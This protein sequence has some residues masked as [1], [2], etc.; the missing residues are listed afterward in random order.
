MDHHSATLPPPSKRVFLWAAPRSISNAF[1]RS[2]RELKNIKVFSGAH[3]RPH[4]Y[5]PERRRS[6]TFQP[7]QS[8]L[9]DSA[10]YEVVDA[11]LLGHHEGFEAV[12]V[13][14][15]ARYVEGRY[16]H[17]VRGG[18]SLFKHTF[19]IRH[20]KKSIPSL[21][22]VQKKCGFSS[23][24]IKRNGIRE[25]YDFFTIVKQNMDPHPI[26]IDADDLLENPRGIMEHYCKETGLPFEEQMLTWEPGEVKDWM[27]YTYSHVFKRQL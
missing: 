6:N 7:T 23:S 12:F 15:D 27:T 3:I 17:Y 25:L 26:V 20:P 16:E 24:R 21:M 19:L 13:R 22:K 2:I 1:E 18:F 10:T 8:E 5:G 9:D 14:N 4:F 11:E